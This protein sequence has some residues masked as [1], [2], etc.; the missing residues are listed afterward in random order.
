[1]LRPA[2]LCAA[3]TAILLGTGPAVSAAAPPPDALRAGAEDRWALD[4]VN[5]SAAWKV[6]KGAGVT[7]AL[8]GAGQADAGVPGLRD[9]IERGPDLTGTAAGD[10]AAE[11]G[12]DPTALA[13][14]IAGDGGGGITG[15]APRARVLSLSVVRGR[16][17][18]GSV[19]PE[20]PAREA[21]S[22]PIAR[23]IRYAISRG[24]KVICLPVPAYGV[25]REEREAVAFALTRGAVLVA[26]VG[27]AG[28]SPYARQNGTSYWAFPAG[29]PG[30]V[31]V[32][33]VDRQGAKTAG[34]SDNLSVLV[35][36]PGDRVPVTLAG[37]RR[38]TASGTGVASA[39]VAG[40]IALIKAKYP[41][42]PPELVS[43]ALTSTSRPH[44]PA[45]YDDKVGFG[46]VD[47]AAAL[48]K[49]GELTAYGPASAVRDDAHFGKG[50]VSQAPTRPGPD[51]VRLWIYGIVVLLGIGGFCAAAV[52]LRRR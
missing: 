49:A 24:A 42:L 12:G 35:A 9:R 36:A 7:V 37:G 33:A 22:S 23:G 26:A 15:V 21:R 10:E 6:S 17:E 30:V 8:L 52:A 27:D 40:T 20:S 11:A 32:A 34:S 38:G 18:G 46:V 14:V 39:I 1:M 5:A 29:Y 41:D 13:S 25:N 45:G 2:A 31:G 28:Q 43:R 51:P 47:A 4:A 50:P 3:L 16:P 48:R 44:P 19:E